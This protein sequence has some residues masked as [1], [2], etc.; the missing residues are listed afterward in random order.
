M[1]ENNP[2]FAYIKFKAFL[3]YGLL[4]AMSKCQ[5]SDK[6]FLRYVGTVY[7]YFDTD[8]D[9]NNPVFECVKFKA[10]LKYRLF[11]LMSKFQSSDKYLLRYVGTI[12]RYFDTLTR[13]KIIQ[14]LHM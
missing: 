9:K 5:S 12:Y 3:K 14:G 1:G 2:G 13:T 8:I 6:Y 7:R 11:L 10:L 4:W